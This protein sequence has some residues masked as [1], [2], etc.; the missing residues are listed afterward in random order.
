LKPQNYDDKEIFPIY[1]SVK[2]NEEKCSRLPKSQPLLFFQF[3]YTVSRSKVF[4]KSMWM[5]G[6]VSD[7][8]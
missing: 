5:L 1:V 4:I 2:L 7:Y 3:T 6:N 8:V